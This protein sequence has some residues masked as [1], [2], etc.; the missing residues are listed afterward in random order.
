MSR[1][2]FCLLLS[3]VL[4]APS[5][6]QAG[7]KSNQFLI[8]VNRPIVYLH[9]VREGPGSPVE[10]GV[11]HE[12]IWM[13]FHNNC[14]LPVEIKTYGADP[15]DPPEAVGVMDQIVPN[16]VFKVIASGDG[17]ASEPSTKKREMPSGTWS[18]VGSLDTIEPGESLTFS[19]PIE[20]FGKEWSIHIPF[21][22]GLP[23]GKGPRDDKA[24]GG[25]TEIFV[26]FSFFDLPEALKPSVEK[27]LKREGYF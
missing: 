14:V 4:Q 25:E 22:F 26:V 17:V 19:L 20:H 23:A 2:F 18:D 21:T 1:I 3:V 9:V 27:V 5:M 12:R 7:D 11:R 15:A 8:D 16:P 24:W 10:L 13:E 6:A